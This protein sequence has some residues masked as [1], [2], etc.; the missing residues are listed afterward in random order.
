MTQKA[1]AIPNVPSPDSVVVSG[2]AP[3]AAIP[4]VPTNSFSPSWIQDPLRYKATMTP[5]AGVPLEKVIT[6]E[7]EPVFM[8]VS[9]CYSLHD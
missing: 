5:P 4:N 3:T 2:S 7:V 9:Y 6:P 8:H 1:S